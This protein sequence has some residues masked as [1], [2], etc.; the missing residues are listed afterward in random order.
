MVQGWSCRER[1]QRVQGLASSGRPM[2]FGGSPDYQT[3][4]F[5]LEWTASSVVNIFHLSG[6]LVLQK[7]TKMLLYVSLEEELGPCPRLHSCF[8]GAPSLSLHSLSSLTG[9]YLNLH[10]GTQGRLLRLE[11]LPYKQETGTKEAVPRSPTASCLVSVGGK[12]SSKQ[13]IPQHSRRWTPVGPPLG[14]GRK[15]HRKHLKAKTQVTWEIFC[16]RSCLRPCLLS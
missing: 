16:H 10:F 7:S 6:V 2:S 13:S 4:T 9:N 1:N 11:T 3:V 5:F 8:M 12:F 14:L 15:R